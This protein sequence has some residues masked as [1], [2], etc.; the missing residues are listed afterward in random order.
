MSVNQDSILSTT[1]APNV[2]KDSSMISTKEYAESNV[3]PI[4]F[5]TS[6]QENAIVLKDTTLFKES[7]PNV[8]PMKPTTN[9]VKLATPLLAQESTKSS[10]QP[11]ILVFVNLNMSRLEVFAPTAT[12]DNTMT[13]TQ[14]DVFANQDTENTEDTVRHSVLQEPDIS[15]ENVSVPMVCQFT[16]VN[17]KTPKNVL[18]TLITTK[19]LN[20]VFAMLDTES[21]MENAAATNTVELMDIFNTVN[22]TAMMDTSGS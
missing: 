7:A 9:T 16:M 6:I 4:K 20:A 19:E 1:T 8:K 13:H 14:I 2:P 15:M 11:P 3:E 22:V 18:F 17:A 12:Q 5:T 10:Q 21:S